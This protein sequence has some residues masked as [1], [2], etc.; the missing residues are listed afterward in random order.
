VVSSCLTSSSGSR[1]TVWVRLT[2]ARSARNASIIA[3]VRRDRTKLARLMSM[4]LKAV[5]NWRRLAASHPCLG[6]NHCNPR[7]QQGQPMLHQA[8]DR[9]A[10]VGR[11]AFG[12][13]SER[14]PIASEQ[15][16]CDPAGSEQ[17]N[18]AGGHAGKR[19]PKHQR[20]AGLA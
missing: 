12:D 10:I 7:R 4:M 13:R 19:D 9:D 17:A 6:R 8:G 3:L 5:R 2:D 20:Y 15:S 16:T 14:S 18:D 11:I 1:P